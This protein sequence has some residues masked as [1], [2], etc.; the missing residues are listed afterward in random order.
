MKMLYIACPY[1][2]PDKAIQHARTELATQIAASYVRLGYEVYSPLTHTHPLDQHLLDLNLPSSFW[3]DMDER[4]MSICDECVVIQA[5]GWDKSSGV[6]REIQWF[7][8]NGKPVTYHVPYGSE[9]L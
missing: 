8:D 6:K 7:R 3:V 9:L 5:Q 2:H 4:F 1:T